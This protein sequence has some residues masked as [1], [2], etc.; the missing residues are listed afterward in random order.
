MT[1][2]RKIVKGDV[3]NCK[4]V[5]VDLKLRNVFNGK[6][7]G[8]G[9]EGNYTGCR[10]QIKSWR[11]TVSSPTWIQ[12]RWDHLPE[13]KSGQCY[14]KE[15]AQTLGGQKQVTYSHILMNERGRRRTSLNTHYGERTG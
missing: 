1:D 13:V 12:E 15:E 3:I 6:F 10:G 9:G 2:Q 14:Q 11:L 5:R 4:E 8:R 7:G